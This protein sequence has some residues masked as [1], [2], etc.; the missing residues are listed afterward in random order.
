MT[1]P[2]SVLQARCCRRPVP[3]DR[4]YM[5]VPGSEMFFA[6]FRSR[7]RAAPHTHRASPPPD[8]ILRRQALRHRACSTVTILLLSQ[9]K[10]A[11]RPYEHAWV[12][13]NPAKS[14]QGYSVACFSRGSGEP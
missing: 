6:A 5:P 7:S 10:P 2:C 9:E 12:R 14:L 8:A 11:V 13:G 1:K 3:A 4:G